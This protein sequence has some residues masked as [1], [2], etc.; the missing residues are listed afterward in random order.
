MT[1]PRFALLALHNDAAHRKIQEKAEPNWSFDQ[2]ENEE[3]ER[4]ELA[5]S[6]ENDLRDI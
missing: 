1:S 5:A 6:E 3:S 2:L 4:L